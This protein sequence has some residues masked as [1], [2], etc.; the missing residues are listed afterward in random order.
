MGLAFHED[1][2]TFWYPCEQ[3]CGKFYS[4]RITSYQKVASLMDKRDLLLSVWQ[5]IDFPD[6]S[7]S[8]TAAP[9]MPGSAKGCCSRDSFQSVTNALK[10]WGC[11]KHMG[12]SQ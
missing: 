7:H 8:Y 6:F 5:V 2:H 9:K 3:Q 1:E 4:S 10:I 12:E 11:M